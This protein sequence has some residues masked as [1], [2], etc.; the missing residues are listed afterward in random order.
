MLLPSSPSSR[1][2]LPSSPP[3]PPPAS[4]SSSGRFSH[5]RPPQF[6]VPSAPPAALSPSSRSQPLQPPS[7][8]PAALSSLS[9]SGRQPL[10]P[11]AV[12]VRQSVNLPACQRWSAAGERNA[13]SR[14][15]RC[16]GGTTSGPICLPCLAPPAEPLIGG[17]RRRGQ[18]FPPRDWWALTGHSLRVGW[19][20]ADA[21]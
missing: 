7:A 16:G 14:G 18:T 10:Q 17:D 12:T 6:L 5:P 11:S 8:T 4:L 21:L 13:S 2:Q 15:C 1:P 19:P 20:A 9:P 3:P